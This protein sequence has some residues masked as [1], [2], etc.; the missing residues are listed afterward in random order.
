MVNILFEYLYRDASNWKQYGQAVFTNMGGMTLA[1]VEAQIRATAG[2]EAKGKVVSEIIKSRREA[3]TS[4]P[5]TVKKRGFFAR[6]FRRG[7]VA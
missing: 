5:V 6:L 2:D 7:K 3:K 4:A 1:D